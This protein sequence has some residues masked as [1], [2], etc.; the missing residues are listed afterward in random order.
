MR[1]GVGSFESVFAEHVNTIIQF[2]WTK[3]P[4]QYANTLD[5]QEN[6]SAR[7]LVS[8]GLYS[9]RRYGRTDGTVDYFQ[10]LISYEIKRSFEIRSKNT[11]F[12]FCLVNHYLRLADP[13]ATLSTGLS[14]F[15]LTYTNA[16]IASKNLYR[17]QE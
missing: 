15:L 10:C 9:T 16:K 6:W 11:N 8:Q 12:M 7:L 17:Y 14:V 2:H 3:M 1:E 4:K 5:Y 13:P